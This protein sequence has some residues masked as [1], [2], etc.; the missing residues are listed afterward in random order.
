MMRGMKI[1]GG[2]VFAMLVVQ[3]GAVMAQAKPPAAAASAPAVAAPA[4][5]A[6]APTP[7]DLHPWQAAQPRLTP[8][9]YFVNLKDGDK[10]ETPFV[11]KFGL[12]GGWG[13]APIAKP[14]SGKSGHHH[15]LVNRDLPLDFKQALPFT[16]QYIHF[17]KGQMQTVLTLPPGDYK[18]R[19]LLADDK[20]LPHFVYSKPTTIT[21]TKKNAT[22]PKTLV[23]PGIELMLAKGEQVRPFRVQFHAA[24]LNVAHQVQ[25]EKDT[26]YFK[27]TM[28]N[29]KGGA[30]AEIGFVN[31]QTEGWFD[32]PPGD[33]TLKLDFVDSAKGGKVLYSAPAKTITVR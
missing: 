18:L 22:D 3:T 26:G 20:H 24:G 7:V 1:Q 9:A 2:L 5:P 32:P 16:E 6:I 11:V 19:L 25:G 29:A 33:Y 31:G 28:Q 12:S 15:L 30:P 8:E 23:S 27:L 17:G 10:I 14:V 13:L 4:V 21:V